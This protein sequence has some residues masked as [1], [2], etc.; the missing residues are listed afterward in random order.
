MEVY[1]SYSQISG[2]CTLTGKYPYE[3]IQEPSK[4]SKYTAKHCHLLSLQA[5]PGD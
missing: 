3:M 1:L 4:Y 2:V 5:R